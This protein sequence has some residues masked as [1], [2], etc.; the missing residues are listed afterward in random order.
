M[1]FSTRPTVI[2]AAALRR[3]RQPQLQ[4]QPQE[5]QH[6]QQQSLLQ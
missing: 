1:I 5:P 3:R 2:A 4:L 6:V